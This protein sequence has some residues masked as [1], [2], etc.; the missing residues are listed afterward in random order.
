MAYL[1][2]I[3]SYE[4]MNWQDIIT[5]IKVTE[6]NILL[7]KSN[8]PK[9]KAEYLLNGFQHGFDLGY[10]GPTDRVHESNN[11]PLKI[12]SPTELWNKIM[13]EVKERRY[14]GPFQKEDLPLKFYMQSPI[15]LVPKADNKTRLIFHLSFDFS[16]DPTEKSLNF[17]TP[18][19][20][21]MVKYNDL[22]SAIKGSLDLLLK[23]GAKQLYYA[24]MD[25]SNAFRLLPGLVKHR[26]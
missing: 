24:K 15:G 10:R 13:K 14:A 11:I 17:H 3:L 4:E 5:P 25:C 1:L 20:M 2:E 6:L 22:D 18:K 19:D 9:D 21:C 8:Y 26:P 12:G 16:M 7:K 23:T